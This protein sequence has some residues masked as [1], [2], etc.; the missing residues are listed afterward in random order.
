MP[1]LAQGKLKVLIQRS[2]GV[3]YSRF[4]S[5]AGAFRYWIE[6]WDGHLKITT[7]VSD[8]VAYFMIQDGIVLEN[9]K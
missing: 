7:Q 8:V 4:D 6:E 3:V 2:N 9:V 1:A 5:R